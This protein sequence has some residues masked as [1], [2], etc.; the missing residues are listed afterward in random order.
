VENIPVEEVIKSAVPVVE[1]RVGQTV[2]K[3]VWDFEITD[4]QAIPRE[5]LNI[6]MVKIRKAIQS[7]L[8]T[9]TGIKIYQKDVI[10]T[11]SSKPAEE[12]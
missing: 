7:G 12:W 5:F 8:R 3:K 9:M 2:F 11:G 10:A 1:T 6:D 4:E